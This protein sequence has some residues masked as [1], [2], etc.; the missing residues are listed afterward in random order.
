MP[1]ERGVISLLFA[2]LITGTA[3]YLP[4]ASSAPA[5]TALASSRVAAA[6]QA[7][8]ASSGAA[9]REGATGTITPTTEQLRQVAQTH[10]DAITVIAEHFAVPTGPD[11]AWFLTETLEP[12][13]ISEELT[14]RRVERIRSLKRAITR[15]GGVPPVAFLIAT[16]PDPIDSNARWQFD[17]TYDSLQRAISASGYSLARFYIPDLD[18]TRNPDTD[19]RAVNRLHERMPGVVLFTNGSR[20]LVLFL[21]FETATSGVHQEAFR[22]AVWTLAHWSEEQTTPPEVRIVG[23]M[24][25]G[26]IPSMGRAMES[27]RSALPNPNVRYRVI[28]GAAT[29]AGN[30][31]QLSSIVRTELSYRTTVLNDEELLMA[32]A[33]FF[34][35]RVERNR[36]A[37]LVESNTAY[38]SALRTVLQRRGLCTEGCAVLP[39][40]LHI[41]RLRGIPAAAS[42][43][44]APSDLTRNVPL[45]LDEPVLPR[46]QLPPMSPRLTSSSTDVALAGILATI[47][48]EHLSVVGL[49]ATD[50]RD[51]LFLAQQISLRSPDTM[52]FTIE[53]DVLLAHSDYRQYT[54]GM[55]V[56]A[57]Y[58]L[59]TGTQLWSPTATGAEARHQFVSTSAHGVYNAAVAILNYDDRGAPSNPQAPPLIDYRQDGSDVRHGPFAWISVVGRDG[60]WPLHRDALCHPGPGVECERAAA[61]TQSIQAPGREADASLSPDRPIHPSPWL[62]A[63]FIALE[64]F[65][66]AHVLWWRTRGQTPPTV[67]W[68]AS[69]DQRRRRRGFVLAV[70]CLVVLAFTQFL[71]LVLINGHNRVL[72]DYGP[73]VGTAPQS[74]WRWETTENGSALLIGLA[75]EYV[76]ALLLGL[77]VVVTVATAVRAVNLNVRSLSHRKALLL[78]ILAGAGL[79]IVLPYATDGLL[80]SQPL[81]LLNRGLQPFNGVS[82]F[83]PVF[84]LLI[85]AYAWPAAQLARVAGPSLVDLPDTQDSR[86]ADL[87]IG[88]FVRL[89]RHAQDAIV[90]PVLHSWNWVWVACAIV[91]GALFTYVQGL[92][93][94]ERALYD[95]FYVGAWV[96]LQALVCIALAQHFRLWRATKHLLKGLALHPM[97]DAYKD[98]PRDLFANRL[99]PRGPRLIH[100]QHAATAQAMFASRAAP[101]GADLSAIQVPGLQATLK[102]DLAVRGRNIA[103]SAT[104]TELV[105]DMRVLVPWVPLFRDRLTSDPSRGLADTGQS[106]NAAAERYLAIPIALMLRD[107]TA[108]LVRGVY[109]IFAGLVLLLAYQV[110]FPAYPR[111]AMMAVTWAYVFVGVST[112]IAMVVSIERDAVMSRL[113]G[114]SAGKIE[115]DAAFLQRTVLPLI[116]ALLT[117]FAVQ[118]PGAGNTVLNWLQPMQTALP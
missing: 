22:Q 73:S 52:I 95:F 24:F 54:H 111:R 34:E 102:T 69:A 81:T 88:N 21:V 49:F 63:L 5:A 38:G 61:Y 58:P 39:F 75:S 71:T 82:P 74:L 53:G 97:V 31:E 11:P 1:G 13:P 114:T 59:F 72:A 80:G 15:D 25:S 64:V 62:L 2:I 112:A 117:L 57:S 3:L 84:I 47:N 10:G 113:S 93:T 26:S 85:A 18:L 116:F 90:H 108:R 87:A 19:A 6:Q 56:A 33:T 60:I 101:I 44:A 27:I 110:S 29:N 43:T 23:P 40:P 77:L 106:W 115:W 66:L 94:T 96:L 99:P 14:R 55:I 45:L 78:G 28:T 12:R 46:D 98:V 67:A 118:F 8:A 4:R 37:M 109:A 107:L 79:G 65:V 7:P 48:R 16:V 9:A 51:K 76:G 30:R 42:P 105:A 91:V 100:L 32:L 36:M 17:P 103:E 50:A 89:L 35:G 20:L 92:Q 83:A 70:T 104:W 41:S 68:W 86:L